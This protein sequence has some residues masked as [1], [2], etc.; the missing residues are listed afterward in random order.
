MRRIEHKSHYVGR[1]RGDDGRDERVHLPC[2]VNPGEL[3]ERGDAAKRHGEEERDARVLRKDCVIGSQWA[4][5]ASGTHLVFPLVKPIREG[6]DAA[7]DS[8]GKTE[9]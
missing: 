2:G 6:D 4:G 5:L 7:G 8:D 3:E 9:Q 1:Q